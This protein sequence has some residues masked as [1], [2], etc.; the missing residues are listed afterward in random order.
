LVASIFTLFLPMTRS[1]G[2]FILIPFL[3][4][5]LADRGKAKKVIIPT[6]NLPIKFKFY[7]RFFL[8]AFPIL[9]IL[10]NF[11]YMYF[12]TGDFFAEL[13]AQRYFIGGYSV[14][15][16]FNPQLFIKNIFGTKLVLHGFMNS[17][18]DRI[19][20]GLFLATLPLAYKKLDKALFYFYLLL[21]L[22]PLF[23]SF[24]GYM[25]YLLPAFFPLSIVLGRLMLTRKTLFFI[26]M[27]CFLALQTLFI[28]LQALSYWVS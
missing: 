3:I 21:G 25:R 23:G 13:S 1:I 17:L 28:I 24:M 26:L 14:F 11:F 9:G 22:V 27:Y 16:L 7:P 6:F 20:F 4:Y 2:I 18:L 8:L 10:L 5:I 19:F 12:K 15:N